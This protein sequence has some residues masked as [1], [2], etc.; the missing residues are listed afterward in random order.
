MHRAYKVFFTCQLVEG[1][2]RGWQ[3]QNLEQVLKCWSLEQ[4]KQVD[5]VQWYLVTPRCMVS[6]R[7]ERMRR[8]NEEKR[9]R[10]QGMGT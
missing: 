1:V 6:G 4:D 8:H 2:F 9:K 3:C 5:Q 7:L 10:R